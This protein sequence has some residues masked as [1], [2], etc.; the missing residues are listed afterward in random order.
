MLYEKDFL[1]RQI[2]LLV[3][4]IARFVFGKDAAIF[5]LPPQEQARADGDPLEAALAR[6]LDAGDVCGAENLLFEHFEPGNRAHLY[7]ALAF[8]ARLNALSDDALSDDALSAYNFS[9][10]EI[11]QGLTDAAARYGLDLPEL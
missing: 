2:Q 5:E 9:R 8:Y 10:E 6:L 3:Q 4:F 11:R 7:A 1:M